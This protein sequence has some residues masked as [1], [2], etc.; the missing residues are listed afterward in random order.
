MQPFTKDQAQTIAGVLR[1]ARERARRGEIGVDMIDYAIEKGM[2]DML[3]LHSF[4]YPSGFDRARFA[5]SIHLG[6]GPDYDE[7]RGVLPD[8][9]EELE[10]ASEALDNA[11]VTPMGLWLVQAFEL[12]KS[13]QRDSDTTG[14][15]L[16]VEKEAMPGILQTV[17]ELAEHLRD[18]PKEASQ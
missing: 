18:M 15:F 3:A 8:D 9:T 16:D 13:I 6:E 2:E 10:A 1:N 14:R 17:E 7:D 12:V 4:G 11:E 5:T